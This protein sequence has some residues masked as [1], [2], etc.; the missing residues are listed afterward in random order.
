MKEFVFCLQ[1]NTNVFYKLIVSLWVCAVRHLQNTQ[2]DMLAIFLQHL[3][4]N[5]RD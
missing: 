5:V 2:N 4:E 3:K 1:I